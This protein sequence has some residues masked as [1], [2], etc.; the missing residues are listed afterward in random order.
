MKRYVIADHHFGHENVIAYCNRPF[1]DVDHMEAELIKNWNRVVKKNDLVYVL[2]DFTLSRDKEYI[3]MLL[4]K[5]NGTKV[6]IMGNHDTLKQEVYVSLGF[7]VATR[8]PM[9]VEH[10]VVLMHE[11]PVESQMIRELTYIFGHVHDKIDPA[12]FYINGVCVSAERI[13]YT[14]IDLDELL[15]KRKVLTSNEKVV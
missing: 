14:P 1:N 5:L 2:G 15:K 3:R 8:K 13:N 11:P 12:E 9:L 4:E 6:L 10:N 7:K